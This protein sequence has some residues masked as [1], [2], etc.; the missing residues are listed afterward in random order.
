MEP[1]FAQ[2]LVTI[3]S[4]LYHLSICNVHYATVLREAIRRNNCKTYKT[5]IGGSNFSMHFSP[6]LEGWLRVV[7]RGLDGFQSFSIFVL[8]ASLISKKSVMLLT[9]KLGMSCW[10]SLRDIPRKHLTFLSLDSRSNIPTDMSWT[11]YPS[12]STSTKEVNP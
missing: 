4:Y 8:I 2:S 7:F 6:S 9:S 1:Y 5:L 10:P 11:M 3:L 12:R